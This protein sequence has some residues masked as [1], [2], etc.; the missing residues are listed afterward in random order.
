ML[1]SPLVENKVAHSI[2]HHES[3]NI[4]ADFLAATAGKIKAHKSK[5]DRAKQE[6]A[7][8]GKARQGRQESRQRSCSGSREVLHERKEVE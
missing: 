2:Q 1:S 5:A 7:R 6:W 3:L 8:K 4:V